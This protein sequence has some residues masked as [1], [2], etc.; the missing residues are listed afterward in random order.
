MIFSIKGFLSE[1]F[2]VKRVQGN[3]TKHY[4]LAFFTI[5]IY[6]NDGCSIQK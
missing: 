5:E 3:D 6:L 4:A 1:H 2:V